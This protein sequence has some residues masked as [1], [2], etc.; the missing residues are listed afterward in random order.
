MGEILAAFEENPHT[1]SRAVAQMVGVSQ[2]TVLNV[3]QKNHFHPYKV[4]LHQDLAEDDFGRRLDFAN[5]TLQQEPHFFGRVMFT[6]ES[7]FSSDGAV[8]RHNS[9]YWSV[10][11]P[12][13][14]MERHRQGRWSII[15]EWCGIV[16]ECVVG[17]HFFD[18][19]LV[20]LI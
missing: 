1:S 7:S 3:L 6:D 18:G 8:N 10:E 19:K 2:S 17:P 20:Q 15:N 11:N 5:W 16:G 9:H 13:W 12:H 14:L 4:R